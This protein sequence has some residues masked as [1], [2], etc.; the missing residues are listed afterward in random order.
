MSDRAKRQNRNPD[1]T[2]AK[3]FKNQTAFSKNNRVTYGKKNKWGHLNSYRNGTR[4][5]SYVETIATEEKQLR[6]Y[7]IFVKG[8][9][10]EIKTVE[11]Q[12]KNNFEEKELKTVDEHGIAIEVK[13]LSYINENLAGRYCEEKDEKGREH[14]VIDDDAVA[15]N[16]TVTH[17][18][19]HLCRHLDPERKGLQ[20]SFLK[21][22]D[23]KKIISDENVSLE[24]ALTVAETLART[25]ANKTKNNVGYYSRLVNSKELKKENKNKADTAN[26]KGGDRKDAKFL[27]DKQQDINTIKGRWKAV[28]IGKKAY[29]RIVSLFSRLNIRKL[30]L[31]DV[32]AIDRLDDINRDKN[33][34][35]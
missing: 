18:M 16:E 26:I 4:E 9:P 29:Q 35:T 25:D 33:G 6:P 15:D 8:K 14:I 12:I 11:N 31:N 30:E 7:G 34:K 23:D 21:T 32:I 13:D 10:E 17:E 28:V 22:V 2:F 27:K 24:E 19:V 1:G 5:R 3:G 20:K